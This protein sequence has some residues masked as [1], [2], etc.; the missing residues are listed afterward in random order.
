MAAMVVKSR[1]GTTLSH[2]AAR[3]QE[4][5]AVG[6]W[7]QPETFQYGYRDPAVRLMIIFFT[8]HVDLLVKIHVMAC[9]L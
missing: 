9:F 5:R 2:L 6:A 7:V 4:V 8:E 1:P 3:N